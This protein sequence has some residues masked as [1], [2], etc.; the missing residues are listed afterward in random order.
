MSEAFQNPFRP[1]TEIYSVLSCSMSAIGLLFV[2]IS[3]A[4]KLPC[5]GLLAAVAA[6]RLFG[7]SNNQAF[8]QNLRRLPFY[9]L[10]AEEIPYSKLALFLGIGFK[11]D[12]RH[13]QRLFL[14]RL[15][16]NQK[17]LTPSYLYQ[18]LRKLEI[19]SNGEAPLARF[20][21]RYHIC[22]PLPPVG[23]FPEIHGIE[24]NEDEVWS[25][26]GERVGHM[27]V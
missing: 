8:K 25:D 18:Y 10:K 9:T 23:G 15:P 13:T 4:V 24:P 14:A 20:A 19:K 11:W 21:K 3:L 5:M 16:E 22:P 2:P 12:Q 7:A 17:Y 6:Y 27:L 1:N 26:I